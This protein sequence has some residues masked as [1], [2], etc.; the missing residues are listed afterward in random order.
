MVK[1]KNIKFYDIE[2]ILIKNSF[3]QVFISFI[4]KLDK[5]FKYDES[6]TKPSNIIYNINL[7]TNL[8]S[9]NSN[10]SIDQY[11]L[12]YSNKLLNFEAVSLILIYLIY[13]FTKHILIILFSKEFYLETDHR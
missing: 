4:K 11:N 10:S 3:R 8:N 6:L 1:V 5:S 9:I 7:N 13:L 12:Y 2:L